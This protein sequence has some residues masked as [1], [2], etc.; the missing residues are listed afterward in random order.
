MV[1]RTQ[2]QDPATPPGDP[3]TT[4]LRS[5]TTRYAKGAWWVTFLLFIFMVINF[6]D[7][8]ILGLVAKPLSEEFGLD[9]VA[10][11]HVASSFYL[12]F[13]IAAFVV[14]LLGDRIPTRWLLLGLALMW[15]FTQIPMLFTTSTAVLIATR[16]L[17]GAAEGPAYGTAN[18]ALHK[19]FDDRHRQVPSSI[20][21]AGACVGPLIAAPALTWVI[22]N[23]GWRAGFGALALIG[24]I[25]CALWA[26]VR[27]EGPLGT[28]VD[29]DTPAPETALAP[30]TVTSRDSDVSLLQ[31][32]RSG[33]WIGA[34]LLVFAAYWGMSIAV[35]WLPRYMQ[36]GLGYSTTTMGNLV[37]LSW[38]I[39][40]VFMIGGGWISQRLTTKGIPT[41]ISRGIFGS[42]LVLSGGLAAV[43]GVRIGSPIASLLLLMVAVGAP[44]AVYAMGQ[45]LISEIAPLRRRG[46]ALGLH[47]GISTVA[48]IIAPTVMGNLIA[49]GTD[50]LSG[51][52][53]GF[54]ALALVLIAAAVAGALLIRPGK[55][56]QRLR[57]TV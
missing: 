15:A 49:A 43:L 33:T 56:A 38:T 29:L 30:E 47:V 7:K 8:A 44:T 3:V 11:G 36:D 5:A 34:T 19:W 45:T 39:G 1:D 42:A 52:T 26:T 27:R 14:G 40:A 21:T 16:V 10:Y 24:F 22:V 57:S 18:H 12:L 54:D 46:A 53:K 4:P 20:M 35:A 48:G 17:L 2:V 51:F 31:I 6:A 55:D 32:I 50:P 9:A 37:A 28:V 41:R 13:S 23:H 25:W